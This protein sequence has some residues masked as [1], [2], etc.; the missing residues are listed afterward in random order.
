MNKGK[1]YPTKNKSNNMR[2]EKILDRFTLGQRWEHAL[3]LVSILILLLTG[4]P[5]KYRM[6]KISQQILATPQHLEL[7]QDIHHI[8]AVILAVEVIYHFFRGLYF[9]INRKLSLAIFPTWQDVLD[10]VQMIRYLLFLTEEKPSFGKYNFEQKFTYWFVVFGIGILGVSGII[11]WFPV[12]V[13]R[14]LPGGI[15][16][17]AKLAHSTEA[18]ITA[19]FIF[20]WHFYHVHIE[21]LN[22]SIFTGHLSKSDIQKYHPEQFQ[23]IVNENDGNQHIGDDE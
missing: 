17:A 8:S 20:I 11:L 6:L 13:T 9:L 15:V 22:L 3:L 5:Q 18:L 19:L 4:L 23:Q 12:L 16:P 2:T 1:Q 21:R 10:A 7:I 14:I